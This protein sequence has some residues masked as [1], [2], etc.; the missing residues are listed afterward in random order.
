MIKLIDH[1][2]FIA[3]VKEENKYCI[4]I[5]ELLKGGVIV[6]LEI[7]DPTY[8][9]TKEKQRTENNERDYFIDE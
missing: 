9:K 6:K 3:Y 4:S 5:F 7:L 2:Y 8:S 1:H